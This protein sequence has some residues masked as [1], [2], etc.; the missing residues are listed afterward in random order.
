M[1][2]EGKQQK[3]SGDDEEFECSSFIVTANFLLI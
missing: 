2:Y 3:W 1:E